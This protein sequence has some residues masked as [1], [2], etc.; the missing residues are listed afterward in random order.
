[1][2]LGSLSA[3]RPAYYDRNATSNLQAYTASVAPHADTQR[4]IVT[5]ATGKKALVEMGVAHS[6]RTNVAAPVRE[7]AAYLRIDSGATSVNFPITANSNNTIDY[8]VV[9]QYSSAPTL[10][11]GESLSGRTYDFSTGGTVYYFVGAKLT[12]FDA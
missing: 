1:M 3:A 8:T 12:V 4:W 9:Y 2:R 11:A 5:V 6:R 10:Y 7:S